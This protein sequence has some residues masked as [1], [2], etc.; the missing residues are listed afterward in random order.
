MNRPL[1]VFLDAQWASGHTTHQTLLAEMSIFSLPLRCLS[2]DTEY[3][4]IAI[5]D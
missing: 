1:P 3:A 2:P 4:P 5:A